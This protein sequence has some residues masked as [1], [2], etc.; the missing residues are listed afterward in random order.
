MEILAV[1]IKGAG[2]RRSMISSWRGSNF[3]GRTGDESRNTSDHDHVRRYA[4]MLRN[5][6]IDCRETSLRV[7]KGP[8]NWR[9][10]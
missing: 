3:L 5:I 2:L 8:T 4:H 7:S 10:P 1:N 9:L 6:S